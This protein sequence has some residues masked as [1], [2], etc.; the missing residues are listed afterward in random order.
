MQRSYP[1]KHMGWK[2]DM[3]GTGHLQRNRQQHRQ[4]VYGRSTSLTS[5]Q[6]SS[7]CTHRK[8]SSASNPRR[9]VRAKQP[10]TLLVLHLLDIRSRGKDFLSTRQHNR[11]DAFIVVRLLKLNVQLIEQRRGQGVERFRPV[12][13][14]NSDL[15]GSGARSEDEGF[16]RRARHE[17][18][19]EGR[20][21]CTLGMVGK[22]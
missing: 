1:A 18:Q 21:N 17:A 9:R 22:S 11:T 10:L 14:E 5:F 3:M 13:R 7:A 12:E 20:D 19:R 2:D 8:L 6:G 4:W 16:T 15:V